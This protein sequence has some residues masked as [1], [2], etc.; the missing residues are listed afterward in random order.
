MSTAEMKVE[1]Y[2]RAE[3]LLASLIDRAIAAGAFQPTD[4][5]QSGQKLAWRFSFG[6]LPLILAADG[7]LSWDEHEFYKQYF[8]AELGYAEIL[9]QI[10]NERSLYAGSLDTVPE[11]FDGLVRLDRSEQTRTALGALEAI[12]AMGFFA[13]SSDSETGTEE[14]QLILSY[15]QLLSR[16]AVSGGVATAAQATS[17]ISEGSLIASLHDQW[18]AEQVQADATEPGKSDEDTYR[19]VPVVGLSAT[20]NESSD[21]KSL[22][23]LIEELNALVG[24]DRVKQ[25]V[26]G[27]TN[28]MKVRQ[29]RL[30]RG[31]AA[32]TMS[33]HLVFTGNP[34]T[35]KTTVARILAGIYKELGILRCGHL[36]ETDR[37]GLVAQYSG[38]T[39][40]KTKDAFS[41]AL[42]GVLFIDE[43]YAL[44]AGRHEH[45]YGYEAVDTLLK[46]M[47]DHR[48]DI[49]VIV[50]G[51]GD[52]MTR[53]LE[54]NPGLLSRFNKFVDFADYVPDDLNEIFRRLAVKSDYLLSPEAERAA[55]ALVTAQY[56]LRDQHFGNARFVRNLFEQIIAQQSN[57]IAHMDDPS[58][59]DLCAI[60]QQDIPTT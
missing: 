19:G 31:L 32:P 15:L 48:D 54:S 24:L 18:E 59:E 35:G 29:L 27:L 50:A 36:V 6:F 37:A 47:E 5:D 38:Q 1:L 23:V 55:T 58:H 21:A 17:V 41:R 46:L 28:L 40:M 8:G 20:R 22:S 2:N 14:V 42:G 7:E 39:P 3:S 4:A 44:V 26:I 11:F 51:Y 43:A 52:K 34:G 12:K 16:A 60:L 56:E 53:F 25:D 57:R 33:L 10:E 13:A 30:E 49:V 9:E 45:D